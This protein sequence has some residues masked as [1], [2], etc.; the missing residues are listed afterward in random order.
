MNTAT[1]ITTTIE[2]RKLRNCIQYMPSE[3][4]LA[5]L[6]FVTNQDISKVKTIVNTL[7]PEANLSY[8]NVYYWYKIK[9]NGIDKAAAWYQSKASYNKAIVGEAT[10]AFDCIAKIKNKSLRRASF[11]SISSRLCDIAVRSS[12]F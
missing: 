7:K 5:R 1:N 9:F 8:A 3:A 11:E 2:K 10:Q 4:E 12:K 6:A